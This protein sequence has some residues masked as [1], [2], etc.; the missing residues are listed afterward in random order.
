MIKIF[1]D[2]N[3]YR[4]LCGTDIYNHL[5]DAGL[6]LEEIDQ[7]EQTIEKTKDKDGIKELEEAI[8]YEIDS[9]EEHWTEIKGE[10]EKVQ[11]FLKLEKRLNEWVKDFPTLWKERQEALG[12]KK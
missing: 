7:I 10:K 8:E 2:L 6:S 1:T 4:V 9:L 12:G 5:E 3:G 11:K